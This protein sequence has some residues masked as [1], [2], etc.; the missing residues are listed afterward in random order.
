MFESYTREEKIASLIE[1]YKGNNLMLFE[2]FLSQ[3]SDKQ[4]DSL[5]EDEVERMNNFAY[6]N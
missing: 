2:I 6:S 5:L 4:L 3:K 1:G